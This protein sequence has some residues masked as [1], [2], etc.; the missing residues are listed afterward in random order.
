[1]DRPGTNSSQLFSHLVANS[2]FTDKQISIILN[3]LQAGGRPPNLTSGAYYT[4]VRQC[5]EKVNAVLYSVVLLQSTGV[6]EE[7]GLVALSQVAEQLRVIWPSETRDILAPER[8]ESVMS[9]M[10]Q[11]IKR[12]SRL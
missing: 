4:Q 6:L 10:S 8:M 9:V 7:Q 1:M 2:I 12:V 5:R 3:R 11:L